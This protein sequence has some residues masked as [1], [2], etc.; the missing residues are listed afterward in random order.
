MNAHAETA[1]VDT[2]AGSFKMNDRYS[3]A[4]LFHYGNLV[5]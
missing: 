1:D 4:D 5:P 3:F 2:T